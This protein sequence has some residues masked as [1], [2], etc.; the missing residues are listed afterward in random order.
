[1]LDLGADRRSEYTMPLAPSQETIWEFVRCFSPR[2]PGAAAF[3]IVDAADWQEPVDPR[4][5]RLAV[6]DVCAR[7]DALRLVFDDIGAE[8]SIRF[9]A[10]SADPVRWHDLSD[11]KRPERLVRLQG[12]AGAAQGRYFDLREG[13]LWTVDVARLGPSRH[14]VIVCLCHLIADGWSTSVL[15]RDLSTAYRHRAG[16]GPPLPGLAL[17]F[18]ELTMRAV[19]SADRRAARAEYWRRRLDPLPDRFAF[20]ARRPAAGADVAAKAKV[21]VPLGRGVADHLDRFAARTRTTPFIALLAAYRVLLAGWTEWERVVLGTTTLG[22][23]IPG[24]EDVVGQLTTNVYLATTV[25]PADTLRDV[26]GRVRDEMLGA[27][28]HAAPF[29]EIA[30]A[31]YPGFDSARPWP[32]LNLYDAWYQ[33]TAGNEP[34]TQSAEEAGGTATGPARPTSRR[35][36]VDGL[37]ACP[38]DV[39]MWAKRGEPGFMLDNERHGGTMVYCPTFYPE[40]MVV[41]VA[42]RYPAVVAAMLHDPQQR[43]GDLARRQGWW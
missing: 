41:E 29:T 4:E 42:R 5:F 18:R 7:H 14:A 19:P 31:V 35:Q 23:N 25:S 9:R 6:A 33:T 26:L 22:R 38:I 20:P 30:R 11:L 17:G 34:T 8:P 21:A 13:P 36:W 39:Q 15:L 24:A 12:I 37:D 3:N 10:A 27:M 32:F 16:T 1:V 2:D 40:E 28:R 43:V